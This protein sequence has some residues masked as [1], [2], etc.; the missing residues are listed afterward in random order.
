MI[1]PVFFNY[2]EKG[3]LGL[4]SGCSFLRRVKKAGIEKPKK[5]KLSEN[6]N[7]FDWFPLFLFRLLVDLDKYI[8]VN[9][10]KIPL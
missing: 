9:L 3:M 4:A 7:G 8:E 6:L 2:V 10:I 5:N 1:F